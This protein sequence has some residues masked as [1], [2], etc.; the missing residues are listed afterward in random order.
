MISHHPSYLVLFVAETEMDRVRVTV[1]EVD[2]DRLIV[3]DTDGVNVNGR[4]VAMPVLLRLNVT[5][6][7]YEPL[8]LMDLVNGHVVGIPVLLRVNVTDLV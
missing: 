5:D 1:V 8:G 4:V 7:V 2:K 3:G 6:L